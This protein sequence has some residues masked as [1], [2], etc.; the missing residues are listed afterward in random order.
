MSRSI[1][2]LSSEEI[3]SLTNWD[4]ANE[5]IAIDSSSQGKPKITRLPK[6]QVTYWQRLLKYLNVGP[7]ANVEVSYQGVTHYL[8]Q[9]DWKAAAN[10]KDPMIHQ[11]YLKVCE[12]A[13][14]AL[15]SQGD[16]KLYQHVSEDLP[17]AA[18]PYQFENW[19]VPARAAIKVFQ[20]IATLIKWNPCLQV[21]HLRE[22]IHLKTHTSVEILDKNLDRLPDGLTVSQKIFKK[23]NIRL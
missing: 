15:V 22:F 21:R 19:G 13:N 2:E 6:D 16:T 3:K 8:S 12:L 7:L 9:Y 17:T 20:K 11:A 1:N 4:L 10:H 23:M 14:R 5:F 18:I